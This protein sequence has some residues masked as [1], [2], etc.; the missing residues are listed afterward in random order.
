MKAVRIIFI[1]WILLWINYLARDLFKHGYFKEYIA[2]AKSNAEGKYE[3]AYGRD[4]Y[5]FIRFVREHTRDSADYELIGLDPLSLDARIATYSFYPRLPNNADTEYIL[6]FNTLHYEKKGY[7]EYRR[8][9]EN[10]YILKRR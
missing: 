9:D 7:A 6:V 4:L 5:Q 8:L 2:L 10:K 3:I 1:I